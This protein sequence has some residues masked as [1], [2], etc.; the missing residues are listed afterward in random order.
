[1]RAAQ[2]LGV[3]FSALSLI[4]CG[5]KPAQETAAAPWFQDIAQAS[6]INFVH[7]PG[8]TGQFYMPEI[9]GSGAALLDYDGDGD[10]DVLLLQ[11]APFD[12]LASGGGC[13]LYRNELVPSGKLRFTD[14]TRESGLDYAG[15]GM[16]VA[17]GDIDND[18]RI[19][20]LVTGFGG[21]ALYRNIGGGKF[22]NV[23]S[24]SPDIALRGRWSTGAAFFDYDRDGRQDL[25]ILTYLDYS[26]ANN[27]RCYAPT[28]EV[29]YCTPKVYPPT[30]A[31]LFH[32]EGGRFVDVTK[33]AGLDRALGRGL[34]VA[35]FDANGDGWP[36]VFVANDASANHLW[37]NQRNGTF[38][39]RALES[40]VAY[41][42]DGVAKAGMGV[43]VGDYDNDGDDD[44]LVLNL[45]REGATLFEN[46]GHGS[47][48]DVSLKTG[49]HGITFP[50]TGFGTGWFDFDNDGW[51]DLFLAHGAVTLREE[52]RGQPYPFLERNVLI[53]NPGGKGR[54]VDESGSAG[55]AFAQ[56]GVSRGAAFGDIDN[57][58]SIDILVTTNNGPA[59][60][61]RNN[62]PHGNWLSV[63]IDGPSLGIGARV[64]V[65]TTGLPELWRRVHTD[66]SYL[67]ASDPRVHFGLGDATRI[68]HVTV[69]WPDGS[70]SIYEGGAVKVNSVF[71]AT[72]QAR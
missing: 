4:C 68:E 47:F 60:I 48:T 58:G 5:G 34:G 69:Y 31:H 51:V 44:V 21:N 66:S 39:E 24:E 70:K 71:H 3:A 56:Q 38:A 23:T 37:M 41:G 67:S 11:G 14:V 64:A 50:Y 42:E 19:D 46:D 8:A 53:R 27:K 9:M 49:I 16:G 72:R 10:L 43:A 20:V 15:Y 61:L 32:N 1:M 6:G 25:I 29:T 30:S 52:Q 63:Q 54:F 12:N 35:V 36:D 59:R 33:K 2:F 17:T 7:Q 18:G 65:K 57:D 26:I 62:R 45:M 55:P 22:R 40:G 13:R 28:G